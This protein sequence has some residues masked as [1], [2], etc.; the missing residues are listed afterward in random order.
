MLTK[1]PKMADKLT[2]TVN[3][4][5]SVLTQINKARAASAR[6]SKTASSTTTPTKS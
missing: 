3:K 4:L 2:D 1:D 6:S 5:D